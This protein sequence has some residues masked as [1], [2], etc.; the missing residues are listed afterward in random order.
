MG[1]RKTGLAKFIPGY[2]KIVHE[3][4]LIEPN[5]YLEEKYGNFDGLMLIAV[6]V[7]HISECV[8]Y[9]M[10]EPTKWGTIVRARAKS[11]GLTITVE[12]FHDGWYKPGSVEPIF[13]DQL[14][15]HNILWSDD[16]DES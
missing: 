11:S 5:T 9:F 12:R 14:E 15:D 8:E 4:R 13:W 3:Y 10:D 1:S 16:E 2:P 7:G 6:P